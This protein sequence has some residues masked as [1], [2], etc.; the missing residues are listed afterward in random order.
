MK[1]MRWIYKL[2]FILIITLS[3]N[4][5]G[6]YAQADIN[7]PKSDLTFNFNAA[8]Q[9]Q[10]K[11][12]NSALKV[13]IAGIEI[14]KNLPDLNPS[15]VEA[16][17]SLA[18]YSARFFDLVPPPMADSISYNLKL[19]GKDNSLP[20]I[21]KYFGAEFIAYINLNRITNI[22]RSD[23]TILSGKDFKN[24]NT[25]TGYAFI[26]FQDSVRGEYFYDPAILLSIQR[27]FAI[28]VNNV[29]LYAHL[30][31]PIYPAPPLAITGIEFK[32][33][34]EIKPKWELFTNS[35]V[36][37][38]FIIESIFQYA[39]KSP[40]YAVFD[41]ATRDS[42]YSTFN[43]YVPENYKAPN[44]MELYILRQYDIEYFITGTLERDT[45]G[46]KLT[47]ILAKFT[48]SGLNEIRKVEAR[49]TEGTKTHLEAVIEK[50]VTQLLSQ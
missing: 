26:N 37:S 28:A 38:Y 8:Q 35:V 13:L 5:I 17:F 30:A 16:A 12:E 15:K 44:Q 33:N 29:N 22:L 42:I 24:K 10:N 31:N 21:A 2:Q 20:S 36:N 34:P 47:L 9:K 39:S 14:G 43:F 25:G 11:R 46:A 4:I 49:F 3:V 45:S 7:K 1:I 27:A 19:E 48:N 23:V 6:A 41:I 18:M 50:T 32:D 40:R